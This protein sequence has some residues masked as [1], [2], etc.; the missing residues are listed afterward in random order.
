[1]IFSA[2]S[3]CRG[4]EKIQHLKS[5]Q[6][7][8]FSLTTWCWNMACVSE[9]ISIELSQFI[10]LPMLLAQSQHCAELEQWAHSC[11]VERLTPENF[12]HK[13]ESCRRKNLWYNHWVFIIIILKALKGLL[14]LVLRRL[15][16]NQPFF[17][18]ESPSCLIFDLREGCPRRFA[19]ATS[20]AL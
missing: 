10:G 8:F 17:R 4:S 18:I 16:N 1:M 13:Q 5:P 20:F 15:V 3:S 19:L 2:T 12:C 11:I 6:Y 7:T 14:G 9:F